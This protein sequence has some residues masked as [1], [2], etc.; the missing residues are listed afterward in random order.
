MIK[1]DIKKTIRWKK[2]KIFSLKL[3]SNRYCLIQMLEVKG[4]IAVFN[5]FKDDN[6]WKGVKVTQL[7]VLFTTHI[8]DSVL[9]R[10]NVEVVKEVMPVEGVIFETTRV[11]SGT[12]YQTV[13]FWEGSENETSCEIEGNEL[14]LQRIVTE[15]GSLKE[16]VEKIELS[17]KDKY[18]GL[19]MTH[20]GDYPAL[21]ERLYLCDQLNCNYDPLREI[22]FHKVL[23]IESLPFVRMLSRDAMIS[24][25]G[26]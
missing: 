1:N 8:L 9:K 25:Y 15:N 14:L 17:E 5:I 3:R 2:D 6:L 26:Y 4:Q 13:T 16:Y 19:E 24:E 21:N 18:Y 7:N 11:D 20:L 23:N 10:S 12:G 22:A